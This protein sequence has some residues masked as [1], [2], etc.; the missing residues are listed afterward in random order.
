MTNGT[1]EVGQTYGTWEVP[2]P[3]GHQQLEGM[4]GRGLAKG[5]CPNKTPPGHEPGRRAQRVGA[6]TSSSKE[7]YRSCGSPRS[8]PHLRSGN[9]RKAYFS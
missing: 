7:G 9:L 8:S 3:F 2:E 1:R 4:E 6:G 5:T